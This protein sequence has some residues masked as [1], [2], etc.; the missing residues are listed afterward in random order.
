MIVLLLI[1]RSPPLRYAPTDHVPT[2]CAPT[3]CLPVDHVPADC[4]PTDHVSVDH[5]PADRVPTDHV[6]TDCAP[7]DCLPVDHVPADCAPTD[8]VSVDHVPADRVPADRVPTDCVPTNHAPVSTDS[9]PTGNVATDRDVSSHDS[10]T[11]Q[12]NDDSSQIGT[13]DDL[14][15]MFATTLQPR[16]VMCVYQLAGNEFS[17]TMDCLLGG[18]TVEGLLKLKRLQFHEVRPSKLY[19]EPDDVWAD[20]VGYYKSS[21]VRLDRPL[22]LVIGDE[23]AIDT[24]GVRRQ[25]FE[26][27]FNDFAANKHMRLF[28]GPPCSL[29]PFYSAEARSS[30]LFTVL[31]SMVAHSLALDGM[32]FPFLSPL[33]YWHN[34]AGEEKDLQHLT[35]EDAGTDVISLVREVSKHKQGYLVNSVISAIFS[36]CYCI[37]L[38]PYNSNFINE[39]SLD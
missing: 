2:D 10:S 29:R 17:A 34:A 6:P 8:H 4:A 18:P 27:V 24:G 7:T 37:N 13:L 12:A 20:A 1:T 14:L 22:R 32:G 11:S 31:G 23:P 33:C 39:L 16:E 9:V 28:D 15:A 19:V 38:L 35:L 5:V 36:V 26:D 3:D 25:F 30:G 21:L